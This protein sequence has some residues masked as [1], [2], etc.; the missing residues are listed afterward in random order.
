MLL[1]A[2]DIEVAFGQHEVLRGVGLSVAAGECVALIGN[3]GSGKSTLLRVLAGSL[4]PDS[5]RV[6][7]MAPPGLLEQRPNLPGATVQD[8]LTEA[9]SWHVKLVAGYEQAIADDDLGR[10]ATLQDRLD[11]VGWD[12]QH[13]IESV[14]ERLK[15]PSLDTPLGNLSGGQSR[16][17]ALARALLCTPDLL[18]LDEPT[19]HLDVQAID[20]LQSFLV[21]YRGAVV[22]VTHDRY[23]LEAVA[24]RIVEI[25]D[26]LSVQ[27][28]GSYTD[29]LVGRA[30]RRARMEKSEMSRVATLTREA[31]W[32][33]RS[34]AARSTKQRARLKRLEVLQDE[35]PLMREQ[36]FGLDL[37]T[38][39]KGGQ[40]LIELDNLSGGYDGVP[41][42]SA[43]STSIQAKSVVGI[44]GANGIGKSTLFKLIARELEPLEGQIHRAP[45]VKLAVIDQARTGLNDD[46]TLFDA[47][48]NGN[49]HIEVSGRSIHVA[50]FLKRFMFR[51]DQHDQ[52]VRDLSGGERMRLLLARL[53][54]NGANV[55]LLDEPTN[56]L[57]LMT[58]RV[59]EEALIDFDGASLVISHD[60]AL[61]DRA[62]S[63]VLSFEADGQI[64]RYASRVQAAEAA[65]KAI[66]R[67]VA[68]EQSPAPSTPASKP[69]PK[70]SRLSWKEQK[71][72]AALPG[73]LEA[74]EAERDQLGVQLSDPST[75]G[76][77]RAGAQS[78][79]ERFTALEAEI[80]TAYAL[81]AELDRSGV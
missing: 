9:V 44:L 32:A 6:V 14:R 7:R 10:L 79:T 2:T 45:R 50:S 15:T 41:L 72:L 23:L 63:A 43:L 19:N 42:F 77:D 67:T 27:Y 18:L 1:Q 11:D 70:P 4:Q 81:W 13:R 28:D 71:A 5:G 54:L 57:D 24:D 68:A 53:L 49:S 20:W 74:L 52:R 48:G 46:D 65:S 40:S 21:G 12:L 64:V 56:D 55:L 73:R 31:A 26:G 62:C 51:R 76:T 80:T 59:L 36:S 66:A 38:G 3:N 69:N 47:A 58:L 39:F 37:Q 22:L 35:R 29:Y 17:V 75:Y 25:E 60:R 34:P 8:A 61:L 33:A 30:E 16:R 78:V